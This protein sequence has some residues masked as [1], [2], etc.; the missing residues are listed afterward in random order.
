M[1]IEITTDGKIFVDGR[2]LK[3]NQAPEKVLKAYLSGDNIQMKPATKA[4]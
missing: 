4:A 1:L 2:Q 3:G